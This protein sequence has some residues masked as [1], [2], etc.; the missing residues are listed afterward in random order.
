[1]KR[2]GAIDP[3]AT[4]ALA[5]RDA[6]GTIHW[7]KMPDSPKSQSEAVMDFM[8]FDEVL[9]EDVGRHVQGNNASA[10][11][12]FARHVG[13]IEGTLNAMS[14]PWGMVH[15]NKWM[16]HVCGTVPSDKKARKH[17]VHEVIQRRF[18]QLSG[19]PLYAAD[20][21]G[22]LAWAIDHERNG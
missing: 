7:R 8:G 11:A 5:W 15:P 3:G 4:G 19:I 22:I 16:R 14:V 21:F 18:N 17:K 6:D 20:A 2:I 10:S 1:M 9:V 13:R 12:K